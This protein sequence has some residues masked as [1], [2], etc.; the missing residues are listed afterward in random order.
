MA[1]LRPVLEKS[2]RA[3]THNADMGGHAADASAH[4]AD[5]EQTPSVIMSLLDELNKQGVDASEQGMA[6]TVEQLANQVIFMVFAGAASR[7]RWVLS[8]SGSSGSTRTS[9]STCLVV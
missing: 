9:S 2:V 3:H 7:T 8:G 5:Q 6:A 1:F 4:G